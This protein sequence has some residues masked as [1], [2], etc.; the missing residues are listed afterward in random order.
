MTFG[1]AASV[2]GMIGVLVASLFVT[3]TAA[4][5]PAGMDGKDTFAVSFTFT[6]PDGSAGSQPGDMTPQAACF[7]LSTYNHAGEYLCGTTP[8][9]GHAFAEWRNLTTGETTTDAIVIGSNYNIYTDPGGGWRKLDNGQANRFLPPSQI[10][11]NISPDRQTLSV[12]GT[13]DG[14]WCISL[15]S[16]PHSFGSWD[17]C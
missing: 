13:Y 11:L 1:R 3:G 14:L 6:A 5:A 16:S 8:P 15:N 10:G 17:Q 4:A 7:A 2:V 9:G 12:V